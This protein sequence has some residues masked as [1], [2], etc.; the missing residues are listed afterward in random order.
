VREGCQLAPSVS[1]AA[2]PQAAMSKP[3]WRK[4]E[5]QIGMF[6]LAVLSG[7]MPL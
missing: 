7:Q 6:F 4:T 3:E 5:Q 2:L 1:T